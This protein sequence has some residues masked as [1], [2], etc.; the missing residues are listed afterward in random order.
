MSGKLRDL[1]GALADLG[2]ARS[3]P[4]RSGAPRLLALAVGTL[5]GVLIAAGV[6]RVS[7]VYDADFRFVGV[8]SLVTLLPIIV[9]LVVARRRQRADS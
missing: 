9:R 2:L 4:A 1:H 6:L 7:G 3:R 8:M 5:L